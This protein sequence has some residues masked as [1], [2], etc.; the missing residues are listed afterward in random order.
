MTKSAMHVI[1]WTLMTLC[2]AGCRNER[3]GKPVQEPARTEIAENAKA[4]PPITPAL[5][6]DE[7]CR[8]SLKFI[9]ATVYAGATDYYFETGDKNEVVYRVANDGAQAKGFERLT[10]RGQEGPPDAN[11]EMIGRQ[12]KVCEHEGAMSLYAIE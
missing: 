10:V 4:T 7:N 3:I 1:W 11:P 5:Q 6:R 8:T 12:F 9:A 2:L